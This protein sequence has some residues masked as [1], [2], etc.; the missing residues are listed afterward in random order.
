MI[1]PD[2]VQWNLMPVLCGGKKVHVADSFGI[3]RG[4]EGDKSG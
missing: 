2:K 1:G 3:L 4:D